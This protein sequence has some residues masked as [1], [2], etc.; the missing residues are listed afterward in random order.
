MQKLKQQHDVSTINDLNTAIANINATPDAGGDTINLTADISTGGTD[1]D[2]L[3]NPATITANTFTIDGGSADSLFS[4][5]TATAIVDF[6]DSIN[7]DNGSSDLGGAATLDTGSDMSFTDSAS[8]VGFDTNSAT[9]SGGAVYL[10]NSGTTFTTAADTTFINNTAG[11]TGG[12]LYLG[13]EADFSATGDLTFTSN[14]VTTGFGGAV[15][16][17]LAGH[18]FYS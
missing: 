16:F 9:E 8:T 6:S 13:N 4:F 3:S 18:N 12:A 1:I 7:M 2:T 11:V 15:F 5:S 14:T 17:V 10:F